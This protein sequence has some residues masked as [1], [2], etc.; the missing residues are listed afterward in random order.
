MARPLCTECG[1]TEKRP[2]SPS[3]CEE[4]WLTKQ[5]IGLQIVA[6]RIR[7][8]RVP[9]P[10]RLP[11]VPKEE[12]PAGRRFCSSCQS[13]PRL[14]D[15]AGSRCKPCA[16]NSSYGQ[17]I[18]TTY[19]LSQA[20]YHQLLTYQNGRCWV[21]HQ[22]PRK[23]RLAVDHDH[24]T[25]R[26]RGLLC[27]DPERGCNRAVLGSLEGKGDPLAMARRLVAYLEQTPA[28]RL[29]GAEV[30]VQPER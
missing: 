3:W 25:G 27:A 8:A 24:E 11:R 14:E 1:K 20:Q 10:L 7:L 18:G 13:F 12:W 2:G 22:V 5:P 28:E 23:R 9:E 16:S 19:G 30:P 4:C 17:H 29:W 15:C 21:C 6:A 26:V